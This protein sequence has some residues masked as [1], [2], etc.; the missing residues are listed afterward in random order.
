VLALFGLADVNL[1]RVRV[2]I[3]KRARPKLPAFVE[4]M[5]VRDDVPLTRYEGLLSQPV[6]EALLE[7]RDRIEAGNLLA[8]A[9]QARADGLLTTA[10]WQRVRKALAT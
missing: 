3:R 6:A 1:R 10:E 8:A 9:Q 5:Q 2:A 4:L 7:C